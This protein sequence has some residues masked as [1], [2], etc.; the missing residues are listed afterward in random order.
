MANG[1]DVRAIA[2]ALPETVER[3]SYGRPGFR[4]ADKLFARLHQ[5]GES[6]VVAVDQDEREMLEATEPGRYFHT[7]H[8]E[9]HEWVQVRLAAV[10]HAELAEILADAW[11]RRAPKRLAERHPPGSI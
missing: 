7:P 6:V 10:D 4:V 2:L 8:Y 5:D 1:D 3:P 9:G 11:R